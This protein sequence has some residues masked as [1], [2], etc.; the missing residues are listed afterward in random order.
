MSAN[1]RCA[2]RSFEQQGQH[3]A[4]ATPPCGWKGERFPTVSAAIPIEDEQAA[5][6]RAMVRRPCPRCGGK[7]E[8]IPTDPKGV[9]S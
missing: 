3:S 9:A 8:L 1:V 7:V 6:E 4:Q 5:I 2:G